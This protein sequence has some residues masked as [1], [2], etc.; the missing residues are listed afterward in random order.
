YRAGQFE[1][2][3]ELYQRGQGADAQYNLGNALARQGRYPEAIAAYDRAL[4]QTPGMADAI[5]NKQA[6][7]AAMKRPPPKNQS[8]QGQQPKPGSQQQKNQPQPQDP[9]RK[10]DGKPEDKPQD[11][12]QKPDPDGQQSPQP[13]PADDPETQRRADQEQRER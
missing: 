5:A 6:V 10:P 7:E 2:A 12:P 4:K 1:R 9:Q 3:A 13:K 11:R 8:G